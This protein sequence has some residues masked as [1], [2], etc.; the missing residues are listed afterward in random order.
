LVIQQK[1][2]RKAQLGKNI[3]RRDMGRSMK[4]PLNNQIE[5]KPVV[6]QDEVDMLKFLGITFTPEMR[7]TNIGLD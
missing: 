5:V 3:G 6:N 2:E 7:A 1:N 4:P